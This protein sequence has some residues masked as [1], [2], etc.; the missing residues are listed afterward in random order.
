MVIVF[1]VF[2]YLGGGDGN[3][4]KVMGM[5]PR[6]ERSLLLGIGK[7]IDR[8]VRVNGLPFDGKWAK[9]KCKDGY[10]SFT[11]WVKLMNLSKD[12]GWG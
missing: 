1:D 9:P 10:G 12:G 3:G 6:F 11:H 8:N 7:A 5:L 2:V 4:R